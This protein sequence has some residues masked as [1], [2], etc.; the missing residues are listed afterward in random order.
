MRY[1]AHTAW[2]CALL[3][4]AAPAAANAETAI[5][6][7]RGTAGYEDLEGTITF[8]DTEAGLRI[9]ASVSHAPPGNHGFHIHE[10][11]VCGEDGSRAGSH[12]NPDD[13]PHGNL[14][15]DGFE[16][17]HAGDLGNL[18]VS[19]AGLGSLIVTVPGLSL[20]G[21]SYAVAGRA[22]ILHAEPDDFGQPVGNAGGRI[23]C[24]PILLAPASIRE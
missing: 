17:A 19:P 9:E 2:V 21:K 22:V 1:A 14:L 24:G 7:L 10:F 20:S 8:V 23:G 18:L 12:Y 3:W 6:P 11:G 15:V 16:Q 5:A 13:A 4:A